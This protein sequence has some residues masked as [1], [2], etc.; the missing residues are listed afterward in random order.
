MHPFA[1]LF[2]L[3]VALAGSV[4]SAPL[5]LDAMTWPEVRDALKAGSTTILIPIGGAERLGGTLVAPVLAYVPEPP[6]HM[7]FPGTIS[8]PS[9]AFLAV[10][11]GAA[12]SLHR[13]G[14]R[15]I[16]LVGDSGDYQPLLRRLGDK[17]NREWAGT[18]FRVHYAAAYYAPAPHAGREDTAR[19][20]ALAPSHVRLPQLKEASPD[21][22]A[23]EDPSGATAEQGSESVERIVEATVRSLREAIGRPR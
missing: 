8:V 17:L 7:R 12:R 6:G 21:T 5:Q 1:G 11:E 2:L 18:P 19:L 15:D 23:A 4:R 3:L 10:V 14:F 13:H 20:L 9:G 16:V 22:G